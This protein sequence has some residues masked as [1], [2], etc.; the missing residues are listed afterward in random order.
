M[1]LACA[2][3]LSWS[4]AAAADDA[5]DELARRHFDSGAAYLE[6]SDYEN[7]LKAFQKSYD[8][9]HRPEI[10]LN[11][12]T[13][14]ERRGDLAAAIAALQAYLAADPQSERAET[15]RLRI[16][17][18]QKRLDE[19]AAAAAPP[20]PT[21]P[22]PPPPA[23]APPPPPPAPPP[24]SEPDRMPAYVAFGVGG[25]G[26]V[27]AV[28]TGIIANGKYQD[29]K[30]HCSPHCTDAD[31]SSAKSMALISTITT[32]VAVVGA[33]VGITLFLTSSSSGNATAAPR[34]QV[35]VGPRGPRASLAL[36]F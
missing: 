35:A 3:V 22:P 7:A 8:L 15:T 32:G 30:D 6:E 29:A 20:A 18:L 12:A 2:A 11:I 23:A 26:L 13:V 17:N 1:A 9:S 14:Q 5:S 10:L 27:T 31:I 19:A 25:V 21:P 33:G 36:E 24:K 16:Q 34:V 4:G 28:V